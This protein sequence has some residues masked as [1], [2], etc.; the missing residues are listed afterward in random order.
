MKT[1]RISACTDTRIALEFESDVAYVRDHAVGY[2]DVAKHRLEHSPLPA[3]SVLLTFDDG[4]VECYDVIRPVLLRHRVPA[5]FFL[6]TGFIDERETFHETKLSLCLTEIEQMS[7]DRAAEIAERL[8]ADGSLTRQERG[9]A[10]GTAVARLRVA[11]VSTALPPNKRALLLWVLA[12]RDDDA[13]G[14]DRACE[15]LRVDVG[16]YLASRRLFVNSSQV[17]Q[18]SAEGF[19][20]G[21]HGINHRSLAGRSPESI[22]REIVYSAQAI[23]DLTGQAHVPFAF[24]YE[25]LTIYRGILAS[26]LDRHPFIQL[27]F[28]S[29]GLPPRRTVRRESNFCRRSFGFVPIEPRRGP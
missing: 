15:L 24:P 29:G 19:T 4:L 11:R 12:L 6:T 3:K 13:A 7:N 22:A 26:I 5:V 10:G 14:I 23:R 28:D 17:K 27:F 2:A 18:M 8:H 20:I 21:A 16:G 9:F 1:S 25:G